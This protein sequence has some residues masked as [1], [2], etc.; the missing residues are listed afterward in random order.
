MAAT[1]GTPRWLKWGLVGAVAGAAL[2]AAAGQSNTDKGHSAASDA[3]Y[4]AA[5]GFVLLGGS[6]ALWD[7]LCAGDTG[8]RRAGMCGG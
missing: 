1:G 7:W 6:I 8:S 4:G 2:F 5:T 3:L